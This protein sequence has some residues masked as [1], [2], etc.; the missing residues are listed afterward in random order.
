MPP[1]P[2][3]GP[4]RAATIFTGSASVGFTYGLE[5]YILHSQRV[6]S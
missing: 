1:Y 6:R 2:A 5:L 4:S 3:S